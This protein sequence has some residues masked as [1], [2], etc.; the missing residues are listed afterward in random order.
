MSTKLA[1]HCMLNAKNTYEGTSLVVQWLRICL[2]TWGTQV[3][4]LVPEDFKCC[5]ATK[6]PCAPTTEAHTLRNHALQQ[7]K[8][9]QGEAHGQQ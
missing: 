3:R 6:P 5:G 2:P 1:R 4:S 9:P 8:P 7:G